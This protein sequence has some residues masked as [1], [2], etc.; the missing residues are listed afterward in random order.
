MKIVTY[1]TLL[2]YN[3]IMCNFV[4]EFLLRI[5]TW[6]SL[7]MM[8]WYICALFIFFLIQGRKE[9]ISLL[10]RTKYKE[11]MMTSL[12]K[13]RLRFS[14]LDMRFHIRDL[15]G[16]GYLRT[17]QSPTGLLVQLSKD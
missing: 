12:Q 15:I 16:S 11:M 7:N 6:L 10:K 14:S 3:K 8:Y 2:E 1:T 13:K 17:V 4:L 9:L 5:L